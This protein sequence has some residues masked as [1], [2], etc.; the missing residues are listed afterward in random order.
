MV[1]FVT[2]AGETTPSPISNPIVVDALHTITNVQQIPLGP[3]PVTGRKVYRRLNAAGA[4][5]LIST[6]ADNTTASINDA[7]PAASV[8]AAAPATNTTS[9]ARFTLT[10]L[11]LGPGATTQRKVYRSAA[12]LTPLKLLTTLADNTTTTYLDARRRRQPGRRRADVR[13]LRA[14]TAERDRACRQSPRSC[15]RASRRHFARPAAGRSWATG[16][17][18]CAITGISG[19]SLTGIPPSGVGAITT[20]ISYGVARDRGAGT[21]RRPGERCRRHPVRAAPGDDINLVMTCD[22]VLAQQHLAALI[23]GTGIKEAYIQDRRIGYTEATARGNAELAARSQLLV[24]VHYT[25]RDI[26]TRSGAT[27]VCNLPAPTNLTGSY[28]IQDVTISAFSATPGHP[29]TYTVMASSQRY[30][31]DDLLRIARGTVGA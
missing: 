22:D 30:S 17:S 29:P 4:F 27:I 31:L 20:S 11:S 2:A 28:K 26:R 23:G 19:N 5:N 8:G 3:A 15:S 1:T 13:Y 6:I 7:L 24:E 16:R 12:G 9:A 25:C 10:N 21:A 14:P 18:S